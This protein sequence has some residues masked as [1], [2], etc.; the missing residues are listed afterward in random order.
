MFPKLCR[1][2]RRNNCKFGE[3]C[4]FN[5]KKHVDKVHIEENLKLKKIIQDLKNTV[6]NLNKEIKLKDSVVTAKDNT[7]TEKNGKIKDWKEH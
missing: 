4:S 2:F 6:N 3:K 7:I 5:H 1:Y